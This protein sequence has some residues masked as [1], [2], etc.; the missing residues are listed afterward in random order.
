MKIRPLYENCLVSCVIT[1]DTHIDMIEHPMPWLPKL[2]LRRAI[3]DSAKAARRQ[4]GFIIIGDTTSRGEEI[5]WHHVR[6][7]FGRCGSP[8][9]NVMIALG[10][11]DTWS[12]TGYEEALSNYLDSVEKICGEKHD[13]QYFSKTVNG[14]KFIFTG[15]IR[16][17]DGHPLIGEEQLAWLDSELADAAKDGRQI[18]VF[19]HECINRSH[20]TPQTGEREVKDGLPEDGSGIGAESKAYET[21]LKKYRNVFFFTGHIH[22]GL[23][24][25]KTLSESGYSSF[26]RDGG[27]TLVNLPSL[28]CGN[29]WGETKR[30]CMGYVLEVYKDRTVIRARDFLFGRWFEKVNILGGKPYFEIPLVSE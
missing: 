28:A 6:E 18:F 19:N 3:S 15:S 22:M 30:T 29:F 8:A 7:C 16:S 5:N 25:E 10:N 21:I 13:R 2:M 9:E 17:G 4:D 24:G 20:G 12:D 26:E 27:L 1:A 14:Y 23:C 11:H